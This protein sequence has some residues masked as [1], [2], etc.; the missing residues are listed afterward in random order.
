GRREAVR[1]S[2]RPVASQPMDFSMLTVWAYRPT[3]A[4]VPL[5]WAR[6]DPSGAFAFDLVEGAVSL[7]VRSQAVEVAH[8][9]ATAPVEGLEIPI[10]SMLGTIQGLLPETLGVDSLIVTLC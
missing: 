9:S 2:G 7:V 1:I 10:G 8:L 3:D 4:P 6:S 5:G